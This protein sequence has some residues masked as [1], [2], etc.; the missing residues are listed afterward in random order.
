MPDDWI[1]L[2]TDASEFIFGQP[3]Y[4]IETANWPFGVLA[5]PESRSYSLQWGRAEFDYEIREAFGTPGPLKPWNSASAWTCLWGHHHNGSAGDQRWNSVTNDSTWNGSG[6]CKVHDPR[7]FLIDGGTPFH[8]DR[9]G[10]QANTDA[11]VLGHIG[12]HCYMNGWMFDVAKFMDDIGDAGF[13]YPT[14]P[15]GATLELE[16]DGAAVLEAAYISGNEKVVNSNVGTVQW[17][18]LGD[19]SSST[20]FGPDPTDPDNWYKGGGPSGTT[21]LEYDGA[22]TWVEHVF[23]DGPEFFLGVSKAQ[24]DGTAPWSSAVTATASEQ[25]YEQRLAVKLVVRPSRYRFVLPPTEPSVVS[26]V[27]RLYPRDGDGRG[28]GGV[29]RRYPP[30]RARRTF[31][32]KHP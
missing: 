3:G 23:G 19:G 31:G 15:P 28:L 22:E 8:Q 17:R 24:G 26:P 21:L 1:E 16:S 18:T 7:T 29:T 12:T 20:G 27:L 13:L 9:I 2:D 11:G 25:R 32:P 30:P 4:V 5:T 14:P 6:A 10:W